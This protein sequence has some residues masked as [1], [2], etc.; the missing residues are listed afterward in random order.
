LTGQKEE[1]LKLASSAAIFAPGFVRWLL[2]V[3]RTDFARALELLSSTWPGIPTLAATGIL[4]G[5]L[6]PAYDGEDV[7][8]TVPAGFQPLKM[9]QSMMRNQA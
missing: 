8:V 4:T 5:E 6:S 3:A 7:F 2:E 9:R 1:S